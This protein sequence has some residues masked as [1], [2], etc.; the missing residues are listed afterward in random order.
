M[1]S[2][3][4]GANSCASASAEVTMAPFWIAGGIISREGTKI[5]QGI[6]IDERPPANG[7]VM[8]FIEFGRDNL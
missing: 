4:E 5:A 3:S 6:L 7:L 2:R 8:S 1:S